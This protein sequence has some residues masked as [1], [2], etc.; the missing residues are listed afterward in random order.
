M[1]PPR[2]GTPLG[3]ERISTSLRGTA[4]NDLDGRLSRPSQQQAPQTSTAADVPGL[5]RGRI[6]GAAP[7][8]YAL[9]LDTGA[10]VEAVNGTGTALA[11]GAVVWI[12]SDTGGRNVIT[13]HRSTA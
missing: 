7:S 10:V 2:R 1:R 11:A 6:T 13:A 9:R 3:V 12:Q 8:G 4:R 5:R